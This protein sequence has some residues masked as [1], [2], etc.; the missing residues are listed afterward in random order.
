MTVSQHAPGHPG[1]VGRLAVPGMQLRRAD[2]GQRAGRIAHAAALPLADLVALAAA[3][4]V[5]ARFSLLAAAYALAVLTALAVGGLHRLRICLRVSDQVGRIAA[6]AALAVIVL[7][8]WMP[9]GLALRLAA[10][11]AACVIA[12]RLAACTALRAAHRRGLLTESALVVGASELGVQ[13]AGI[14][15]DHPE[16]GL[17]P[18]GLVDSRP[19]HRGQVLPVL[20]GL[21]DLP[22]L[23][24]EFRVRRVI[25]CFPAGA[26]EELVSVLRACRLLKADVCLVPRLYELG[27]AVP[28]ACLDEVWGIPLVPLRRGGQAPGGPLLKRAFDVCAAAVLLCLLA[29]VLAALAV[30]VW[31]RSGSPVL[32]RQVRVTGP[33]QSAPILKLRTLGEHADPDTCWS[34]PTPWCTPLGRWMRS[35]HLDELPQLLN[36]LRGQ[37]SL[38]GPRPERPYFADRFS[39]QIPHYRDRDRL[40]AGMTGWAQVNGL[41]GDTSIR[42]RVRFDNQYIEY[43][44][45]WL[46]LVILMRTLLSAN[47]RAEPGGGQ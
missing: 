25:V 4:V 27:A 43:W 36:V 28:M 39:Q 19:A 3:I 5:T 6:P 31:L 8:R 16:L 23:V 26:D 20:G 21:A 7:L 34:V 35:T 41:H 29:P 33:G 38:V 45:P 40:P 10:A 37:M 14:L 44:S 2:L 47:A 13:I 9:P 17:R 32:F 46:D 42:D 1:P 18:V 30:A 11:S 24:A 15:R 12:A 22:A